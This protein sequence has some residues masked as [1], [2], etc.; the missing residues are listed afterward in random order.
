MIARL[1]HLWRALR[2]SRATH[3]SEAWLMAHEARDGRSGWE[4]P[5][6]RFPAEVEQQRTSHVRRFERRRRTA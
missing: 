3:V 4:G 2:P 6:W 5:R 1:R